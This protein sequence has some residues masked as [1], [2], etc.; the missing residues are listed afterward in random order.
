M[1]L[2]NITFKEKKYEL[3]YELINQDKKLKIL[4][5]HGWGANKEL[6]KQAFEKKLDSFCQIYLDLPG[7]GKSSIEEALNSYDYALIIKE[8]LIQKKLDIDIF[9][10]HSFGGKLSTL[11]CQENQILILLSSAGIVPKK[12][13]K[14]KT[15]IYIFKFF[16]SLGLNSFYK[17]F[18][19][20]DVAH[21]DSLM[22]ETFKK[23]VDENYE[24]IFKNQKAKTLI[25]WGSDDKDTSLKSGELIHSLIKNSKFYPLDGDHFFFLQ[26]SD[27]IAKKIK[28]IN[29]A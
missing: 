13:L 5:L 12:S 22:Y 9:L 23:V 11:L 4:I 8:F 26:H 6:M 3:S 1:A 24:A 27:F 14:T 2:T 16:K 15:K 20:K 29:N 19:S 10:G 28:G 21:M 18:A 17:F 25:F 7:F